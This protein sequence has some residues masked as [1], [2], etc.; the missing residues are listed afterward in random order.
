MI[1]LH[2][3]VAIDCDDGAVGIEAIGPDRAEV[4]HRPARGVMHRPSQCFRKAG[5]GQTDLQHGVLD[6]QHG[7]PGSS[8]R[9][10]LLLGMLQKKQRGPAF[11]LLDAVANAEHFRLV[12]APALRKRFTF[13]G[14]VF[15][16]AGHRPLYAA[17]IRPATDRFRLFGWCGG[18]HGLASPPYPVDQEIDDRGRIE[19]QDL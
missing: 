18:G 6:M 8:E 14:G 7:Q 16:V 9:F 10:I 15:G 5:P 3:A 13:C 2:L 1:G 12:T 4:K 17:P 11:D 19:G